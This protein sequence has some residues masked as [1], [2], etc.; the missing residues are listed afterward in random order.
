MRFCHERRSRARKGP[1]Q[2]RDR[3]TLRKSVRS[4]PFG[5]WIT[6]AFPPSQQHGD[7]RRRLSSND[8][9]HDQIG[10][11]KTSHLGPPTH[12][13]LQERICCHKG[14]RQSERSSILETIAFWFLSIDWVKFPWLR[15][16]RAYPRKLVYFVQLIGDNPPRY[17]I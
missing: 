13:D 16:V 14:E 9:S 10:S 5:T 11:P 8:E 2:V 15:T 4:V 17:Q 1:R 7:I 3:T 12:C 6:R